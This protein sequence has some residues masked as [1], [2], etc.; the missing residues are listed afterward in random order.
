[1][2]A[3]LPAPKIGSSLDTIAQSTPLLDTA[4][5][6]NQ[7]ILLEVQAASRFHHQVQAEHVEATHSMVSTNAQLR[8]RFSLH[9]ELECHIIPI[10]F[11]SG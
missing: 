4:S 6:M 9:P 11:L 8:F 1:M 7:L 2:I 10:K 3:P 5:L